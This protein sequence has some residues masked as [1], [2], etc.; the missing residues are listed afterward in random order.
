[1]RSK[2]S[3]ESMQSCR[4]YQS[5]DRRSFNIARHNQ[6]MHYFIISS[7]LIWPAFFNFCLSVDVEVSG[8]VKINT[9][10]EPIELL[11]A[12]ERGDEINKI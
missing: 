2:I 4:V 12:R 9:V 6:N 7:D 8:S 11:V 10:E 3:A 1:M 5:G